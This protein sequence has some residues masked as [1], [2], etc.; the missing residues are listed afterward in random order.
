MSILT[1]GLAKDIER[2]GHKDMAITSIWPAVAIESAATELN[3]QVQSAGMNSINTEKRK[4]LRKPKIY[5]DAIL[6]MIR[7]PTSKVNGLVDTDEDFLRRE[8]GYTDADFDQY[9]I[10][11]GHRPRR[12]MPK[13]FPDLSVDEQ[14][15]QGVRMDSAKMRSG[16]L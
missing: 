4:D 11:P 6:A 5:S 16:K 1:I 2:Q 12:I 13:K 3:P 15:D 8:C 7:A 9:N 10:V 14:D